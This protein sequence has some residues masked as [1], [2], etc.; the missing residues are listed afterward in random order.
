MSYHRLTNVRTWA[1]P[2]I[3]PYDPRIHRAQEIQPDSY[4]R[5]LWWLWLVAIAFTVIGGLA[6]EPIW[7]FMGT[8]WLGFGVFWLFISGNAMDNDDDDWVDHIF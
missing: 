4:R 2:E 3:E 1:E 6:W 8:C 7:Y 5:R